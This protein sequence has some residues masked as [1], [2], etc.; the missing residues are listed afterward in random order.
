M[1]ESVSAKAAKTLASFL[2]KTKTSARSSKAL[3]ARNSG[4]AQPIMPTPPMPQPTAPMA[5]PQRRRPMAP[6]AMPLTKSP[7]SRPP[8]PPPPHPTPASA[9]PANRAAGHHRRRPVRR[10]VMSTTVR[11]KRAHSQSCRGPACC[12]PSRHDVCALNS[13][14]ILIVPGQCTVQQRYAPH[15]LKIA[16]DASELIFLAVSLDFQ[17]STLNLF[18]VSRARTPTK[19]AVPFTHSSSYPCSIPH[20]ATVP[21]AVHPPPARSAFKTKHIFRTSP[22]NLLPTHT[23][24]PTI[25]FTCTVSMFQSGIAA[26]F[27]PSLT[28][29]K[30]AFTLAGRMLSRPAG[31]TFEG[32]KTRRN[33]TPKDGV[34]LRTYLG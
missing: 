23:Q 18:A 6:T 11:A 21:S 12:A 27:A 9:P 17:L 20:S 15:V 5:Q 16:T 31:L 4:S 14:Y 24:I 28:C 32:S 26:C 8:L 29:L 1:A 13:S 25:R 33:A 30:S 19:I 2:K 3:C 10:L 7:R 22:T 34:D